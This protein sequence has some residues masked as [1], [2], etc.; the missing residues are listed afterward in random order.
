MHLFKNEYTKNHIITL[1]S[2]IIHDSIFY[3]NIEFSIKYLMNEWNKI[4]FIH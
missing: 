2:N 4:Y 1:F 3:N